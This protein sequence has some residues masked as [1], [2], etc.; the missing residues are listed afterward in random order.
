M[1]SVAVA[2]VAPQFGGCKLVRDGHSRYPDLLIGIVHVLITNKHENFV[3]NQR[4]A[5]SSPGSLRDE[6]P[7]SSRMRECLDPD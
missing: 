6:A 4:A 1:S 5:K 3:L 2:R 7:D